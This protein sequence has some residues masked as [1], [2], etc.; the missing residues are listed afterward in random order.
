MEIDIEDRDVGSDCADR[1]QSCIYRC[2]R[3][4]HSEAGIPQCTREIEPRSTSSSAIMMRTS[5]RLGIAQVTLRTGKRSA[6]GLDDVHDGVFASNSVA[7][8]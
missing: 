5:A 7:D 2:E 3:S 8:L 6:L 4:K 1:V